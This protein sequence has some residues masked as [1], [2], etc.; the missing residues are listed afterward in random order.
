LGE[1]VV[2]AEVKLWRSLGGY[3]LVGWI[4]LRHQIRPAKFVE[5]SRKNRPPVFERPFH[6]GSHPLVLHGIPRHNNH[7]LVA[8]LQRSLNE[9]LVAFGPATSPTVQEVSIPWQ[10]LIH[11][12]V[13]NF[14]AG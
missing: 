5:A 4:N 14:V 6:F 3:M 9:S 8:P 10:P 13:D 1:R 11:D 12:R 2:G 7:K